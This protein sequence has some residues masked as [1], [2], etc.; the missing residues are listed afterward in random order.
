MSGRFLTD[1]ELAARRHAE[2]VRR[3]GILP[4]YASLIGSGELVPREDL[5]AVVEDGS[6]VVIWGPK[7]R[8]KTAAASAAA[9][10][11]MSHHLHQMQDAGSMYFYADPIPQPTGAGKRYVRA[12]FATSAGFVADTRAAIG[13]TG[14]GPELVVDRYAQA[15]L[16]VLDDLG[17]EASRTST[18]PLQQVWQLVNARYAACRPTV[19]TTQF[20]PDLLAAQLAGGNPESLADAAAVVDRLFDG[21]LVIKM[22][23]ENLRNPGAA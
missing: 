1:E 9:Y 11:Y 12:R 18:W 22:D 23:G 14:D 8:G 19:V 7:G 15:S 2:I 16:L 10:A 17:K 5:A 4:R 20:A 3:C 21:A 13:K 6:S